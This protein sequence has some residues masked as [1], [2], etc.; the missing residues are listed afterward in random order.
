MQLLATKGGAKMKKR[1]KELRK[2]LGLT[3]DK[4][5]SQLGVGG[6]AISNI[7]AGTRGL[8]DQMINSI[9]K[10]DWNGR[11]VSEEWLRTGEGEMFIKM[12]IEEEIASLI[13]KIPNEPRGSFKRKLLS[14]LAGLSEDQW[15]MLADIAEALAE[16]DPDE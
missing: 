13:A 9:C 8:T 10:T 3:M 2:A 4:F 16:K 14:V 15:E 11:H 6:S 12:D 7:E 5:G 1:V